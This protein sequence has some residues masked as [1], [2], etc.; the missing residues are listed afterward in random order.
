MSDPQ[1][2]CAAREID[3]E[4]ITAWML[5]DTDAVDFIERW[6]Y[7]CHLWDDLI[8]KDTERTSS[9]INAAFWMLTLDIPENKFYQ[10]HGIS[11]RPVM[12]THILDWLA[13]NE[14]ERDA[15]NEHL[16]MAYT[17]RCNVVSVIGLCATLLGG[18]A[19]GW[20]VQHDARCY[21]QREPFEKYLADLETREAEIRT[22]EEQG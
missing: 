5:N 4:R 12:A 18:P 14:M 19:W 7:V 11:L 21:G 1:A 10:R 3:R 22:R 13:A 2:A 20:K 16:H 8:D 9:D 6:L 15:N 17:L